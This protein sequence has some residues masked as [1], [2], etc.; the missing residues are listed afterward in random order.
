M[1]GERMLKAIESA[2]KTGI[3]WQDLS[4]HFRHITEDELSSQLAWMMDSGRVHER[5]GVI[6]PGPTPKRRG[7]PK[8]HDSVA[9]R[10]EAYRQRRRAE[11][12]RSEIYLSDSASWR[13]LTLSKAWGCNRSKA[14]DRLIME[15]DE[16]YRDILFPVAE[17]G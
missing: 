9:G 10:V 14:V 6:Y 17:N 15:A 5:D 11:G 16:R 1:R 7:R 12:R 2:G 4:D 3:P 8:V 13:L